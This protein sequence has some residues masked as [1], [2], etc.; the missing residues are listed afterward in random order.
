MSKTGYKI[1]TLKNLFGKMKNIYN[2]YMVKDELPKMCVSSGNTKIGKV[3][4]VSLPPM[5]TCSNCKG[6]KHYCYDISA[7][8]RYSNCL[9]ARIRNLVVLEKNRDEYFSRID[10]KCSRRR[11]N[12]Y[13]RWHVAGD[14]V[15]IDYF[16]RMVKIAKKHD[17][18]I[19]WTYTKNYSVV[20]EYVRQ[21]GIDSIPKNF[22]IMFSEWRGMPIDN[23]FGFPEFSCHFPDEKPRG[24]WKCP[25]NC[26]IC[27]RLSRGC[28]AGE[29]T[30]ADL[31]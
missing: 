31:H 17:D 8:L 12:K 13:F 15:D 26:D 27:K 25:G 23:P 21:H 6:C 11:K 1:E 10:L 19:F 3:L 18:F 29:N 2:D 7:C 14:I 5:M 20:N 4:N 9:D 16:D 22:F 30:Y 24:M 28:I